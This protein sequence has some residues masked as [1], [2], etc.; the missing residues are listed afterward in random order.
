VTRI[1]GVGELRNTCRKEPSRA[2]QRST[3]DFGGPR[4]SDPRP[5]PFE[6]DQ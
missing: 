1:A 6:E 4:Q 2:D 3:D 5:T